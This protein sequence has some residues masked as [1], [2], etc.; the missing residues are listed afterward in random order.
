MAAINLRERDG[1]EMR[2]GD[3][4]CPVLWVHVRSPLPF[5]TFPYLSFLKH[6]RYLEF[7]ISTC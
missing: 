1:L 4:K 6:T 5:L 7:Y 3:V 2:V